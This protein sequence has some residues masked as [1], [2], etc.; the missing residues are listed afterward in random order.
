VDGWG[1][2]QQSSREHPGKVAGSRYTS[3]G[4]LLPA[5]GALGPS[6]LHAHASHVRGAHPLTTATQV[7]VVVAVIGA[8]LYPTVVV[9]LQIAYGGRERPVRRRGPRQA[10]CLFAAR[11]SMLP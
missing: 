8:G 4:C 9:P 6:A 3:A 2:A 11:C 7:A 1:L 5:R 10:S